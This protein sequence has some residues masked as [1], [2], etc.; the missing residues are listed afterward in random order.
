MSC[1]VSIRPKALVFGHHP[2][3]IDSELS[4]EAFPRRPMKSSQSLVHWEAL[5]FS[6][7]RQVGKGIARCK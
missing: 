2:E 6:G 5:R 7:I 1:R 4:D 3:S